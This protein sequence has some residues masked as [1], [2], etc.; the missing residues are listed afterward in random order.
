MERMTTSKLRHL[1]VTEHGK[2]VGIVSIGDVVRHA[3]EQMALE[4]NALREYI[5]TA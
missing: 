1:P 3:I 5:L 4:S 2:L